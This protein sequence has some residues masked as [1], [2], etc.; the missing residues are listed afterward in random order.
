MD[1]RKYL[2]LFVSEATEHLAG[3]ARDLVQIEKAV[4]QGC[5]AGEGGEVRKV[6]DSL[7]RHAHSVKGMSASMELSGISA[8]ALFGER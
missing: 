2:S 6:I 8:V 3:Y 1:L 7:F 4:R 5:D